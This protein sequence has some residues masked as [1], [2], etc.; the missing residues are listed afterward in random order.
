MRKIKTFKT[1]EEAPPFDMDMADTMLGR[2]WTEEEIERLQALGADE[3]KSRE[4][5]F[6]E[7]GYTMIFLKNKK[8][9][10]S[11]VI[12]TDKA[13]RKADAVFKSIKSLIRNAM[14]IKTNPSIFNWIMNREEEEPDTNWE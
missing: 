6:K 4:A 2:K 10:F 12:K 9:N 7:N 14:D 8:N 13:E 3:I 5:T 1:F 11:I